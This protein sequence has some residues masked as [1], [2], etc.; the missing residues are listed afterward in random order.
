MIDTLKGFLKQNAKIVT[1][2]EY[3]ASKRFTDEN[4][5]PI[6]WRIRVLTNKELEKLRDKFTKKVFEPGT[7]KSEEQFNV[8]DFTDELV[9]RTIAFPTLD[10]IDLQNSWGVSSEIDLV[11]AMLNGGEY[12]DL[13]RAIQEANGFETGFEDKVKEV[14]NS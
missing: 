8:K 4:G 10:D 5:D 14:K 2:V 11:K 9:T 1:E 3:V 12:T 13:T 7:R 6:V